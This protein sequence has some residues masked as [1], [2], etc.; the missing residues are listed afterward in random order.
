VLQ[1]CTCILAR[2]TTELLHLYH[3]DQA[4]A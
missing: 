1:L 3:H 2:Q 4:N